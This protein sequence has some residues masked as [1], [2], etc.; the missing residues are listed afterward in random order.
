MTEYYRRNGKQVLANDL[1]FADARDDDAAALIVKT[2]G[3]FAATRSIEP[4]YRDADNPGI[5]DRMLAAR[6]LE[7]ADTDVLVGPYV[8]DAVHS[9]QGDLVGEDEA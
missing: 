3:L 1:H 9:C 4:V 5:V 7:L 6:P 8:V 2:L